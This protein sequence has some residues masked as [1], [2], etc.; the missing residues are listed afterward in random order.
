[1]STSPNECTILLIED[2]VEE[3]LLMRTLIEQA[4]PYKVTT[5]QDGH[6]GLELLLGGGWDLA[7]FDLNLPGLDGIELI[8]QA[9]LNF[10]DLPIMA[11]TGSTSSLMID[12]AVRAG[13]DYVL[14]KPID[15]D[16][17]LRW[18]REFVRVP[19]GG[20]EAQA[21]RDTPDAATIEAAPGR[22]LTVIAVGAQPGDVE[23]GCG[24]VLFRHR[25]EGH[26]VIILTLAGG[27]D[28]HSDLAAAAARAAEML[29]AQ[30]TSI[31][32]D[33]AQDP[34]AAANLLRSIIADSGTGMLYVPSAAAESQSTVESNRLALAA[35]GAVSNVLAYQSPSATFDFHPHFFVD[36]AP[37]MARKSEM[38][39]CYD[40]LGLANV[41]SELAVATAR[42]WRRFKDPEQ[43]E[44]LEVIRRG[45][46]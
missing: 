2:S 29:G 26:K 3:I 23:M 18:I 45:G 13:A 11:V 38:L 6:K 21:P 5:A 7:L 33:G 22:G 34:E 31:G 27:G 24:G 28:P 4:G 37:F 44:P 36:I 40:E 32:A 39:A 15:Q 35:A 17:L 1:M 19:G 12:S 9:R 43:V 20:A 10:P 41:S 42:Y 46:T 16:E 8:Q 14:S 30:V 25:A